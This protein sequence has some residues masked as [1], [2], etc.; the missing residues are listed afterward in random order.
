MDA[1]IKLISH[2]IIVEF[3]DL[4]F[5]IFG[6]PTYDCLTSQLN[7]LACSAHQLLILRAA[8]IPDNSY[9]SACELS[10]EKKED[11]AYVAWERP[12]TLS[13]DFRIYNLVNDPII[14]ATPVSKK[15]EKPPKVYAKVNFDAA[16]NNNKTSYGFIIRDK[17]GCVIGGGGG[18][19][20][21]TLSA[22]WAELYGF[23]ENLKKA[24]SL[25]ISKVVFETDN[26][27]FVNRVKK[28]GR[29]ITIMGTRINEIQKI[30]DN[31]HSATI[32]WANRSCNGVADFICKNAV[33]KSFIGNQ[34]CLNRNRPVGLRINRDIGP[35]K[36]IELVELRIGMNRLS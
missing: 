19:K 29:D 34:D 18:F 21:E 8:T 31:L 26:A 24:R 36:D 16:I 1:S 11:D 35:E 27:S 28:H 10:T 5:L 22:E 7:A 2:T 6:S 4:H 12:K 17:D 30:M 20:E 3:F 25:N 15:W 14:L 13:H 23:E 32:C 9:H 33:A